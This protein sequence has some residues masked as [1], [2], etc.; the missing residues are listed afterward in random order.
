MTAREGAVAETVER[1]SEP[2]TTLE[3]LREC[4]EHAAHLLP[5]Q[6]PITVFIHH[7]TLHAFEDQ[8]FDDGVQDGAQTFG[9][10]PYLSE[11]VY[12]AKLAQGRIVP[13]DLACVLREDLRHRAEEPVVRFGPRLELRQ[14]MM[15]HPLRM[16]PP[17]ELRW[18]IAETEA[19]ERYRDDVPAATRERYLQ[20][21]RRWIMRDF[22][23]G[24][25]KSDP[26]S[27][28]DQHIRQAL[29]GL[30]THFGAANVERW[31]EA[32]WEAFSL[33]A[34][35]RVCRDGVH[36]HKPPA[37][38]ASAPP[39]HRDLLFEACGVDPD[40]LVHDLLIR[41]C[42]AFLD[43]GLAHWQLPNR[44]QGFWE[45]FLALYRPPGGPPDRWLRALPQEIARLQRDGI[46]PL[47]SIAESLDQLDVSEEEWSSYL[48]STFLALRGWGG[49]IHEVETRA[50]RVA[51]PV[52]PGA[53][54]EFLAVRLL[55]ERL[56]LGYI[57]ADQLGYQGSLRGL[58]EFLRG[59][60]PKPA[61]PNVDQR[62]FLVFQLAQLLGWLPN[63]L[64]ELTRQEWASL[65]SE[66]DAF[67]SVE[68]RRLFHQAFERRYR[69]QTLDAITVH[70]ERRTSRVADPA[71]QVI[72]CLDEREE[73][74]RRHLEE[75]A[76]R[77]ET[78]GAAGFFNVPMYYRGAAAAHFVPLCPVIIRP[79]HW[80]VE[81][82]AF[83]EEDRH[84]RRAKTRRALGAA[85]HQV[86]VGSRTFTGGAIL[87]VLGIVASIPLV[88]RVLF[89]RLTARIRRAAGQLV[90]PPDHT[91][92]L[93]ER[94]SLV[95]GPQNGEIG[96]SVDEMTAAAERLLR[97][98][99]LTSSFAPVVFL[100][101]HGS[102][103]VNNPHR[104]A[105][106]CG[107]CGGNAGG[108]NARAMAQT[109]ND[110]RVRRRLAERGIEI[111]ET[112]TFI[113]GLHNTCN[114]T[115]KYFDLDRLGKPQQSAYSAARAVLDDACE[116][117]A[118]ER[119][120]RFQ[121]APLTMDFA[122][123]HRHVEERSEDLAQTRP[124]CG[125]AT[126]ALCIVGRRQRTKDL[127]LDRRAFLTSYDP[128][129]DDEQ[130]TVLL[131]L[132][133]AAVPVCAGINLEYYFSYIDPAGFGCGTKLPHNVTS[134][135]GIMDGAASDLR[136]GLPWQMVEIHDPVRLLFII[137]TTPET[138]LSIMERNEVIGRTIRNGWVQ[139]AILDPHSSRVQVYQNGHFTDYDA[140]KPELPYADSS[141]DWYRG[142]REHLGYAVIGPKTH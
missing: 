94:T 8:P 75:L 38:H 109:L 39:R 26:P 65:L 11:E 1:L 13:S 6:G 19:L 139:L 90:Q 60:V 47:A 81:D 48:S 100:L 44:D 91:Q 84:R 59:K 88:A 45:S 138:M 142:W 111:A 133:Q 64:N 135:L 103:S 79:Q 20:E 55:L 27:R 119:C 113:G 70:G 2:A 71:F 108:P 98:V 22:R 132:L 25:A 87:A 57:A 80:V 3:L 53:L 95:P 116:R 76:P 4:I 9:C 30:F 127:Y 18:F 49:M 15:E 129:L 41:F 21:T 137:E 82:V 78:F 29:D 63:E 56:A 115:I 17:A 107:A 83:S 93:L 58:R 120:R 7:N 97:D 40:R 43:Q 23:N 67:P 118:H 69:I 121:S 72:C 35:W 106:D 68:R 92:L 140:E 52:A 24:T 74:F 12:R 32:T 34:L 10:Q 136:T 117:N 110:P 86:H 105:Y 125:H 104:S 122:A 31:S 33:Q 85:S 77:A 54:I 101:G 28:R 51:H 130:G 46:D 99:G 62:A 123:A 114:D 126:N 131:R 50:D 134:L 42:A 5:A 61:L 128:T 89:P 124:E 96:F 73:S 36:G 37:P 141:V 102:S 14:A 66:I 16:A 112:T